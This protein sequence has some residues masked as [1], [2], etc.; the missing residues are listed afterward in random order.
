[1]IL[2]NMWP[3]WVLAVVLGLMLALTIYQVFKGPRSRRVAWVRRS[4]MIVLL[5]VVGMNPSQVSTGSQALT[6]NAELYF[7][8]DRTGSMAAEDYQGDQARLEGV[9]ADIREIVEAMPGARYSIVAF[10]SQTTRQ[11]PL[12]TDA[13]AVISW[14]DTVTQEITGYSA[15]SSLSRPVDQLLAT[16]S[17]SAENNPG[18]VRL[19][20]LFSD[21]EETESSGGVDSENAY[22]ALAPYLDGG[23]VFGYGTAEGGPM[24]SYDGTDSTGFRNDGDFIIDPQTDEPAISRL[25]EPA[26]RN[27]AA[28]LGLEY[29]H[30]FQPG[31]LAELVTGIDLDEIAEDGRMTERRYTDWYWPAAFVLGLL[32]AWE[33]WF[34]MRQIPRKV[35]AGPP[36]QRTRGEDDPGRRRHP[37]GPDLITPGDATKNARTGSSDPFAGGTAPAESQLSTGVLNRPDQLQAPAPPFATGPFVNREQNA[38]SNGPRP[39]QGGSR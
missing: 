7:V 26:L 5:A 9:A 4:G 12:T 10:D 19:M 28:E 15:G 13:R 14:A 37:A 6:S 17:S 18:N 21:G 25:D 8:V 11:L 35:K 24:R 38:Q 20:F 31:G 39:G 36:V 27:I 33:A 30:R 22:A 23:A 29:Q 32:L 34:L 3:W 2:R 1:M 16:L